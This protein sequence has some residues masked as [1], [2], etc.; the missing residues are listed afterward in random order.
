[1]PVKRGDPWTERDNRYSSRPVHI[2]RPL[3]IDPRQREIPNG[4][5][6]PKVNR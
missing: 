3:P 2:V 6:P 1:M 4:F 5:V